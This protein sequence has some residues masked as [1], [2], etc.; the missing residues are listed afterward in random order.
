[1]SKQQTI[2]EVDGPEEGDW[3]TV[4]HEAFWAHGRLVLCQ[5]SR[6]GA[7][8]TWRE[9]WYAEQHGLFLHASSMEAAVLKV[10]D[11]DRWWP[12]V[13]WLNDHGDAH[14]VELT[15]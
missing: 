8:G 4:D 14:Q 11:L 1:M 6:R 10:M 12:N 15:Y 3:T 9:G 7:D 2:V 5:R 13:W